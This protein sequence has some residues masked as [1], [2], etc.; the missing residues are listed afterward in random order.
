MIRIETRGASVFATLDA[1]ATR[2]ALSDAMVAGLADAVARAEAQPHIRA[3]VIRGAGGTFCAGGDF[4]RFRELMA[5]AA[6]AEGPDPI[7]RFN[8]GFGALLDRL[9]ACA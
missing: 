8:R 1:P 9:Q 6:P 7:A 5:S 2:H 4:S 3:L